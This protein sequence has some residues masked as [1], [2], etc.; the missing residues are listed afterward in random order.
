[1]SDDEARKRQRRRA[2]TAGG[3]APKKPKKRSQYFPR[4]PEGALFHYCLLLFQPRFFLLLVD[5]WRVLDIS[6]EFAI[7]YSTIPLCFGIPLCFDVVFLLSAIYN[8]P[9]SA[10]VKMSAFP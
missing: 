7:A 8:I 3:G 5:P 9:T 1:M 2:G 4:S 6:K 10:T